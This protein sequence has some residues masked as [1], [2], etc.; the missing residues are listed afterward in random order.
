M[1]A[2]HQRTV[3]MHACH[4]RKVF[5][6]ACTHMQ[7][8][9]LYTDAG[10]DHECE[11]IMHACTQNVMHVAPQSLMGR[12][13][14]QSRYASKT[15]LPPSGHLGAVW[16]RILAHCAGHRRVASFPGGPQRGVTSQRQHVPACARLA[17]WVGESCPGS[18]SGLLRRSH[19]AM[20]N[21]YSA[22][23]CCCETATPS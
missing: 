20:C 13:G 12:A 10:A 4:L 15:S 19:Q 14:D 16:G 2:Y 17:C 11:C 21:S 9:T 23:R 7:A 5:M 8:C 1:H 6:H 3:F 18:P 22:D